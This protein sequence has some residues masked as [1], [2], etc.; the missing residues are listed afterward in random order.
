MRSKGNQV[1]SLDPEDLNCKSNVKTVINV[2]QSI[3]TICLNCIFL[4]VL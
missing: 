3:K 2:L 4:C 1:D